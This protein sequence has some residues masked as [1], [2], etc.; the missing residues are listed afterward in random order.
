MGVEGIY[1]VLGEGYRRLQMAIE[2]VGN[3]NS[4]FLNQASFESIGNDE[5]KEGR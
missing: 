1:R 5:T 4:H 2:V 3:R